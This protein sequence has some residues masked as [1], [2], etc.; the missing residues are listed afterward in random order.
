[1]QGY[2]KKKGGWA[3]MEWQNRYFCISTTNP[4]VMNYFLSENHV[5]PQGSISLEKAVIS[6]SKNKGK[7]VIEVGF[8]IS[9]FLKRL[10]IV[11]APSA[12]NSIRKKISTFSFI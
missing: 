12:S 1:M 8:F 2:L 11:N 10:L 5:N 4:Q 7:N 9:N 3:N 6:T